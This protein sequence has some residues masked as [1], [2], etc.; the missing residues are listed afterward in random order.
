MTVSDVAETVFKVVNLDD[1]LVIE[2]I[3]LRPVEGDL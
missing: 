1:N 3:V 2:E